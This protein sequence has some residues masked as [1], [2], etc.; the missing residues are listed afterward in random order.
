MRNL[1]QFLDTYALSHRNPSNQLIHYVC[2]PAIFVCTLA[3]GWLINLQLLGVSGP[4][5][6]WV[7]ASSVSM[8][9]ILPLFYGRL[10][11]RAC[12]AMVLVSAA[13]VAI[14][15]AIDASAAPLWA[16]AAGVFIIAWA[17]QFVG[18]HIEGAKPN[19]F[20]DLLFLLIGPL[21]VLEE[22][23]V[24]LRPLPAQPH[25]SHH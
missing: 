25:N 6:Y 20:E 15:V 21:F 13:A 17:A 18:H 3:L 19:F 8:A 5:G 23:G 10:G 16:V 7:N 12:I 22:L 1:D 9:L 14:I 4:L 11:L 24:P 2:V